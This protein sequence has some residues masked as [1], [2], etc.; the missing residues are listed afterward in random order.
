MNR[1]TACGG[2]GG[3]AELGNR[4][5]GEWAWQYRHRYSRIVNVLSSC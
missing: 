4:E 5:V 2:G 3:R 1:I